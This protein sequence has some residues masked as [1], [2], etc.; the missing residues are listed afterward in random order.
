MGKY[1]RYDIEAHV[2]TEGTRII[3][4]YVQRVVV[5]KAKLPDPYM[6]GDRFY[7]FIGLRKYA[8]LNFKINEYV[9]NEFEKYRRQRDGNVSKV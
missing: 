6:Y 1:I 9:D 4:Y 7:C 5:P 3:K 8:A 2:N